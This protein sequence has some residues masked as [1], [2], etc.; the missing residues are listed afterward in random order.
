MRKR[1]RIVLAILGAAIFGWL[2]WDA[3]RPHEPAY[4]GKRLSEW[5]DAYNQAGAMDKIGPVSEAIRT[6]G[7]N[8]LPFLLTHIKHTDSPL[9]QI[10]VELMKKQH[11]VKLPFYGADPYLSTSILALSALGSNAAPICPELLKV[12]EE[13]DSY[14]RGTIPLLAIGPA[15]IPTLA[16]VCA[17]T[18]EQ[19]RMEAVLMIAMLKSTPAPWF[20]WG[21]QK[22]PLN[23]RPLFRPLFILG[24]AV[25][26]DGVRGM[27]KLLEDPD[28]A[29]RRA[30][31]DALGHYSSPAYTQVAKSAV[32]PLLKAQNDADAEV[33]FAAGKTLK[34]IDPEAAAK[35][36]VK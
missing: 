6:M 1:F 23:G 28:A 30:S 7:T 5:L 33:R 20:S 36:G 21:W 3:L 35:A 13:P 22:A 29:V 16:K 31:A 4:Q 24:Y 17:S 10:F 14:W 8:S 25:G 11:W 34:I 18:N 12:A 32:K 27:I 15:S 9:E 26:D 19:V 2:G